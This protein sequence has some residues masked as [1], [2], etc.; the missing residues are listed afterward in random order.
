MWVCE[1]WGNFVKNGY[2]KIMFE[3]WCYFTNLWLTMVE[4][5]C[6]R[7]WLNMITTNFTMVSHDSTMVWP[8]YDH[9]WPWLTMVNHATMID[10]SE[11]VNFKSQ[12]LVHEY[13]T[14]LDHFGIPVL[15]ASGCHQ[16]VLKNVNIT[17][18]DN[19]GT[20]EMFQYLPILER[21]SIWDLKYTFSDVSPMNSDVTP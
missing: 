1:I 8:W 15:F 20:P 5:M 19:T 4:L 12:I 18:P 13:W 14:I 9:G 16:H 10:V 17:F 11:K 3:P 7:P 6:Y 21:S 2:F